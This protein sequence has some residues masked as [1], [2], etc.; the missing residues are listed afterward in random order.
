M[1][2]LKSI[3]LSWSQSVEINCYTKM[4]AY[5][6]NYKVQ[7]IWLLIL[8]GSTGA[9]F[10]FISKS[11]LDYLNYDVVSQK[12]VINEVP[13]Q[14]PAV[15]F[16]D[17]NPFSTKATKVYL[18]SV[19]DSN[20]LFPSKSPFEMSILSQLYADSTSTSDEIRM[21]LGLKLSQ[22]TCMLRARW[23]RSNKINVRLD[24]YFITFIDKYFYKNSH[25]ITNKLQQTLNSR[26]FYAAI[27]TSF[28]L[29][30]ESQL[31]LINRCGIWFISNK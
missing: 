17:N 19:A 3:F 30:N 28:R 16:C 25:V 22:I 5:R 6:P 18:K 21:K 29:L 20:G 12:S 1:G 15:T 8:L 31:Y 26:F 23:E 7:F 2:K 9:T 27:Y 14:F 24:L 11:I 4:M 10:Y 13:T